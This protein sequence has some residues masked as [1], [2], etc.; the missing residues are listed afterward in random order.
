[1]VGKFLT[2]GL[3]VDR[4]FDENSSVVSKYKDVCRHI[5]GQDHNRAHYSKL[6]KKGKI[7]VII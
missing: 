7:S 3:S 1:M 4:N 6:Q 5:F 2:H